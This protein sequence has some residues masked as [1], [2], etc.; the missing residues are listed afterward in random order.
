MDY[1]QKLEA[2]QQELETRISKIEQDLNRNGR[3][4]SQSFSEQA[5]ERGNT[6]VLNGLLAEGR[7]ELLQ[8]RHALQRLESDHFGICADCEEAISEARLSALPYTA[9][10]KDCAKDHDV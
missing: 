9:H 3:P 5:S 7:V 6:D 1:Q 2:L 4:I 10:C 8:V